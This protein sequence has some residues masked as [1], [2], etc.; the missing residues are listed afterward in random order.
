MSKTANKVIL[1]GNVGRAPES[2]TTAGG[3]VVTT[4]SLAVNRGERAPGGEWTETADWFP[5]VCWEK[6]AEVA[7]EFL[8][9][10]SRVYVEGRLQT[11]SWEDAGGQKHNRIE[12]VA[13]DLILLDGVREREAVAATTGRNGHAGRGPAADEEL[14][15]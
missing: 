8:R 1:I 5:I 7:A 4:F 13:G 2:K 10:G 11:R 3:K 14:D 9:K 6:L 15:E 12:V